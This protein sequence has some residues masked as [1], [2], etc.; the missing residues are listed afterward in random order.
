[1]SELIRDAVDSL[2]AAEDDLE[3]TFGA[4]PSIA[5]RVPSRAEWDQPG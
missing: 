5:V 4:A 2:L 3:A 1:M